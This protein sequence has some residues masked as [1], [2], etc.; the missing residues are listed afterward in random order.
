MRCAGGIR[1]VCGEG[2]RLQVL[3]ASRG[4]GARCARIA[5]WTCLDP[6]PLLVLWRAVAVPSVG[7]RLVDRVHHRGRSVPLLW[8]VWA[9]AAKVLGPATNQH[10][11]PS[12]P[13]PHP[14][15]VSPICLPLP[16]S[17]SHT[18]RFPVTTVDRAPTSGPLVV[19]LPDK[20]GPV[21]TGTS[22]GPTAPPPQPSRDVH[23]P[24]RPLSP[25]AAPILKP[26]LSF[27]LASTS[28]AGGASAGQVSHSYTVLCRMGPQLLSHMQPRLRLLLFVAGDG[29]DR[30]A[31]GVLGGRYGDPRQRRPSITA[32]S[33][34][35]SPPPTT[36][37]AARSCTPP[38]CTIVSCA[39]CGQAPV[40]VA[41]V[42]DLTS[43]QR[44]RAGAT[45]VLRTRVVLVLTMIMVVE[46]FLV[47]AAGSFL[48]LLIEVGEPGGGGGAVPACPV[49]CR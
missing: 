2:V 47:N 45:T 39:P 37:H 8:L 21:P 15:F 46:S 43:W 30:D 17:P 41:P 9:A 49:A 4:G 13:P 16:P 18:S 26:T 3:S 7:G 25:P 35:P 34:S 31:S 36:M 27:L 14:L 24:P 10:R 40:E 33:S 12:S 32:P 28:T 48:P 11:H 38:C 22:A 5:A 44:V 42:P 1:G 20:P 19:V 23:V 29:R 6:P